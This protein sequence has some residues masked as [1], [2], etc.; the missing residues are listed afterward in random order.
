M[1]ACTCCRTPLRID[2]CL[3]HRAMTYDFIHSIIAECPNCMS[4]QCWVLWEIPEEL[5]GEREEEKAA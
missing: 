2:E 1:R 4:T 3:R 5:M